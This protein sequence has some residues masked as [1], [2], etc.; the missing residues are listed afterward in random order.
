[1]PW[2]PSEGTRWTATL[3]LFAVLL[4]YAFMRRD[5]IREAVEAGE[6]ESSPAQL[7][8]DA[9]A[10][11]RL[12]LRTPFPCFTPEREPGFV[13]A[14][15]TALACFGSLSAGTFEEAA[16]ARARTRVLANHRVLRRTGIALSLLA[17]VALFGTALLVAGR[18]GALLAA[19]LWADSTWLSFYGSGFLREDL[20][21]ALTMALVAALIGLHRVEDRRRRIALAAAAAAASTALALTRLET[22][23][24][25][26]LLFASWA[27]LRWLSKKWTRLDAALL[28]GAYLAVWL[29]VAP[30]LVYNRSKAGAALAPHQAHARFWRNHEFAGRPG[31][32]TRAEVVADSYCGPPITPAGYVFGLHSFPE[33]VWRYVKGTFAAYTRFLW[34]LCNDW[35]WVTL[36]F[37]AGLLAL[38]WKRRWEG[39]WLAFA[40]VAAVMPF[41]FVLTLNTVLTVEVPQ[42]PP[43]VEPRFALPALPFAFLFVAALLGEVPELLARLRKREAA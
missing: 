18:A 19:T 9:A 42:V 26:T 21:A 25:I 13:L 41:A 1:M 14:G 33:V 6:L 39:A 43:G 40:A 38:L 10:Y 15:R 11:Y 30:Y 24:V 3:A 8:G 4:V 34:R 12:A 7:T 27:G 32:P 17:M 2:P 23:A 31:F 36:L 35:P 5:G 22:L 29:L 28:V 20:V 37:P 16:D